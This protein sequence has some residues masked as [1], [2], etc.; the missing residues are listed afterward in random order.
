VP[1]LEEVVALLDTQSAHPDLEQDRMLLEHMR[2]RAAGEP[3]PGLREAVAT[4]VQGGRDERQFA[5]LLNAVCHLYVQVM[6]AGNPEQQA[7][8]AHDLAH[9][10]AARP[11][12]IAGA[13]DFLHI[14]QLLLRGEPEMVQQATQQ[15]AALPAPLAEALTTMERLISGEQD[16]VPTAPPQ[17]GAEAEAEAEAE[18]E[19]MLRSLSPEQQAELQVRA[20]VVPL[21]RQVLPVLRAPQ[22]S[23][24][25]R[26]RYADGVEQAAAQAAANEAEGSPWLV[27]ATVLRVVAGWLRG[28][29]VDMTALPEPYR[30]LID[31]MMKGDV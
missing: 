20:Q 1:L 14:L 28:A 5:E 24:E 30:E 12:P 6:Q 4:W 7:D 8:L 18:I 22:A 21:L 11:L 15:R 10:R 25:E 9:V 23:T 19:A 3:P 13:N 29:P 17:A 26:A 27:A 31:T 16:T 2:R